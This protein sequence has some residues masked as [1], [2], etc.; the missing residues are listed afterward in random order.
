[1]LR[2]VARLNIA[3][4]HIFA[5][6][7][8][9]AGPLA[10]CCLGIDPRNA[11]EITGCEALPGDI[12]LCPKPGL[13]NRRALIEMGLQARRLHNGRPEQKFTGRPVERQPPR[14][15]PEVAIWTCSPRPETAAAASRVN[16]SHPDYLGSVNSACNPLPSGRLRKCKSPPCPR[17]MLRAILRPRP[18]P[19]VS[20]LREGSRR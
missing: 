8:I 12:P 9:F 1:M 16:H 3:N 19:P 2:A 5:I 15:L 18:V 20:G 4:E 14:Q 10:G 11:S 7:A 13:S 6:F 17:A